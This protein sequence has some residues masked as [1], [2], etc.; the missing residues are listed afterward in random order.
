M[1]IKEP[2][3]VLDK[4]CV[5]GEGPIYRKTNNSLYYFDIS[6]DPP[7]LHILNLDPTENNEEHVI[8]HRVVNLE[9]SVT[10]ARFRK[11]V[12]GSLLCAYYQ[13][14]A[15]LDEGTGKLQILREIIPKEDKRI[16]R[17]ND[18]GI[19]CNGNFWIAEIDRKAYS[20]GENLPDGYGKP[21]GRLWRYAP[22]GTLK[23]MD[24][25]LICGNG[26]AWSPDNNTMYLNDS[27]RHAIYAYDFDL[28]NSTIAKKRIF[29]DTTKDGGQPDGM[30]IDIEGNI[31]VAMWNIG[32]I[33]IFNSNGKL[34][35]TIRFNT[36]YI[37]S[38]TWGGANNDI[39]YITSAFDAASK[40]KTDWGGH[41]FKYEPGVKGLE[42][43]YFD[44]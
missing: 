35:K 44:K 29:A 32:S 5:L 9:D 38:L 1:E 36:K 8:K 24:D 39:L 43:N 14:I 10:V 13:G 7:Q 25:G 37:S 42:M 27:G 30:T 4:P 41:L 18:G 34:Q 26:I 20:Y 6:S 11:N 22:D 2:F 28:K 15:F 21:L 12:P 31:W 23:M 16:R 17:L 3:Y 19:D 33:M 40:Q